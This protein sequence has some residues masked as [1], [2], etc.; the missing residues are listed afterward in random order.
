[1]THVTDDKPTA[2]PAPVR[3]RPFSVGNP[4]RPRGARNKSTALLEQLIEGEA[5]AIVTKVVEKALEGDPGMLRACLERL[6]SRRRGRTVDLDLPPIQRAADVSQAMAK[7]VAALNKGEITTAE[8]VE[9]TSVL[10]QANKAFEV[11]EI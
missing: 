9:I 7:V 10:S 11:T 5:E 8:A 2:V 4:G 3:G 1:M 6:L